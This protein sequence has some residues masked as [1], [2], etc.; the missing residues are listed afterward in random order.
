MRFDLAVIGGGINGCGIARDAAGRGLSV[1]LIEKR[2]LAGATSSA[3][4]KLIH[5]GLRYLEHYKFLLVREALAER[6]VLWRMAPHLVSPLRFVLPHRRGLRPRWMLRAGLFLYDHLA[7]RQMLAGTRTEDLRSHEHGTPLRDGFTH[8]FAYSDCAVDDARLAI[9][10]APDAADRGADIRVRTAATGFRR[11]DTHWSVE[12]EDERGRTETVDAN[13]VVNAAGPWVSEVLGLAA[14]RK[15]RTRLV[16]GSHIVVPRL[17]GHDAA[18]VLQNPD[19]RIV[20]T[21]PYEHDFTLIGTTDRDYAG[22]PAAV[23]MTDEECRYLCDAV[24]EAF[25]ARIGPHDVVWSYAGVRALYD[26]GASA[27]REATREYVLDL[28]TTAAPVLTVV[29]GKIT[30]YRRLAEAALDKIQPLLPSGL[31]GP[32]T[33]TSS[34]PGGDFPVTGR[35]ALDREIGDTHPYLP[36]SMIERLVRLYGTRART[37]LAGATSRADLGRHFGADLYEREIRHLVD[38]EWARTADD[39]VWRRTKLGLVLP[40]A[41]RRALGDWLGETIRGPSPEGVRKSLNVSSRMALC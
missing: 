8:A 33:A 27:A 7:P 37:I 41:A 39:I 18:Y 6:E 29:G 14:G 17:Y 40:A 13:V 19:G 23:A 16:Q 36:Q 3:S 34:L 35:R 20:F 1:G 5:G 28:D 24:N 11:F 21:I 4:S 26:D 2:D 22:D 32:W 25:T 30:T 31:A 38:N 15:A 10:T 12:L 9:L